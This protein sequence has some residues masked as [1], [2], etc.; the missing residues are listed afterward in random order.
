MTLAEDD[1][2][3][4]Q[5]DPCATE[6]GW[7]V[8][9]CTVGAGG[10]TKPSDGPGS[11]PGSGGWDWQSFNEV[12]PGY[13]HAAGH[14][15]GP[16]IVSQATI[17]SAFQNNLLALPFMASRGG[18]VDTIRTSIFVASSGT[19]RVRVGI[20][21]N[22]SNSDPRPGALIAGTDS[23]D[24]AT[25]STGDRVY[26]L[27]TPLVLTPGQIYWAAF[28]T[29]SNNAGFAGIPT[30]DCHAIL[31]TGLTDLASLLAG[32]TGGGI[33]W[34]ALRSYG[35]LPSPFPTAVPLASEGNVPIV[36]ITFSA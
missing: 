26:T 8:V 33:G 17:G 11:G 30:Q 27:P 12:S 22:M 21:A 1:T 28:L 23:G 19:G 34:Q 9:G 25:S 32:G 4:L 29:D 24:M 35:P 16:F 13:I 36:G 10:K 14:Q 3:T 18:T 2:L 7:M 5:H 20:Y 6:P 31:G 15:V